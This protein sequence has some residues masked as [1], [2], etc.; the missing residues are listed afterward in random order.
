MTNLK[1]LKNCKYWSELLDRC[2][3]CSN[4]N[5]DECDVCANRCE[6]AVYDGEIRCPEYQI[7]GSDKWGIIEDGIR[8]A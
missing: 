8:T 7:E 4:C 5:S 1:C 2:C 6:A 3:K